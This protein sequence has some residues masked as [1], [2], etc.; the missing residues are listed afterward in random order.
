MFLEPLFQ[1]REL[2]VQEANWR[3]KSYG[4]E[5]SNGNAFPPPNQG[6]DHNAA[7]PQPNSIYGTN[8]YKKH[9]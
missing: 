8:G 9:K 5:V 4:S 7:E 3:I 2:R 6:I 1:R